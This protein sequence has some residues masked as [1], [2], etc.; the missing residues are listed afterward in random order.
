ML[1]LTYHA[2]L[3]EGYTCSEKIVKGRPYQQKA[4]LVQKQIL[5]RAAYEG[6]TYN[7]VAKQK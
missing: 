1:P 6:I 2:G 4:E 3:S 5:P 7:V